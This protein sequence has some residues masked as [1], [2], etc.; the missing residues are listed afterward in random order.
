MSKW[1]HCC[2]SVRGKVPRREAG[3]VW[4]EGSVL[5]FRSWKGA[6]AFIYTEALCSYHP[7]WDWG[8][9]NMCVSYKGMDYRYGIAVDFPRKALNQDAYNDTM[10]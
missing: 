2:K 9:R 10:A 8:H 6:G 1:V 3:A 4:H 7:I 5:G